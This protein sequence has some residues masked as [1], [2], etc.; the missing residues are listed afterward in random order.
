MR[1]QE[2]LENKE[3]MQIKENC[4]ESPCKHRKSIVTKRGKSRL[5]VLTDNKSIITIDGRR[6]SLAPHTR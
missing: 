2:E 1:E 5:S 4:K 6:S 3:N